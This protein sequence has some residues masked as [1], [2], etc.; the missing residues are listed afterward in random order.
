MAKC[1]C[2]KLFINVQAQHSQWFYYLVERHFAHRMLINHVKEFFRENHIVD[3]VNYSPIA[4][5]VTPHPL[6]EISKCHKLLLCLSK[7][8]LE[9]L[10]WHE[11]V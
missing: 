8:F 10:H 11:C 3:V 4:A 7:Q 6:L 1:D 9:L 5:C 2:Q